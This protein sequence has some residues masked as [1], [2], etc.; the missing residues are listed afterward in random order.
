MRSTLIGKMDGQ[1]IIVLPPS[2]YIEMSLGNELEDDI[3]EV[4]GRVYK[5]TRA[6]RIDITE[7]YCAAAGWYH[8]T[9]AL[10]KE[11]FF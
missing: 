7:E 10:T 2:H 9:Y 5:I 6:G 11:D 4:L 3:V 1:D 8:P